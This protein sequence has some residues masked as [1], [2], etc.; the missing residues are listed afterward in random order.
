MSLQI[1]LGTAN[2]GNLYGQ[3][4]Q[5]KSEPAVN[6]DLAQR[7]VATARELGIKEIDTA[8]TYGPAQ[9][10]LAEFPESMAFQINSKIQWSGIKQFDYY[11][12]QISEISKLFHPRKIQNIQFHNWNCSTNNVQEF[13]NLYEKLSYDSNLLFGVTT[14][15]GNTVRD[16]LSLSCFNSIQL[17][18]NILNQGALHAYKLSSALDKP[19]LY[20]RSLLLQGLLTESGSISSGSGVQLRDLLGKVRKLSRRWG[21]PMHEI[22][23]RFAITEIEAGSVVVGVDS[24]K[25]LQELFEVFNKGPLAP[26]LLLQIKELDSSDNPV[27]DP[28]NWKIDD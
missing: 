1:V 6:K 20:V 9:S 14:Y 17:E 2:F 10:W 7:I 5:F 11:T 28:R 19:K 24:E 18:F 26:E 21:L 12:K 22:A 16:A 27:V 13:N 23:L 3:T 25:Q 15:G 8:L 4:R